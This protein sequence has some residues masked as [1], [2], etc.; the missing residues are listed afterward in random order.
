M[1]RRRLCGLTLVALAALLCVAGCSMKMGHLVTNSQFAYPNSNIKTLGQVRAEVSRGKWFTPPM[2]TIEDIR[3]A[4]QEALR[5]EE[6]ANILINFK[7]DTTYTMF[8]F[9]SMVKYEIEGE[10]ARMDV[11][12]QELH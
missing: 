1:D 11:G 2:L 12:Q 4:Y 9:Y 5:R 6:G 8:P 10:A 3:G 7:E